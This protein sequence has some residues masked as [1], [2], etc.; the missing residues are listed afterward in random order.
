MINFLVARDE[1]YNILGSPKIV[2]GEG[3]ESYAS[4]SVPHEVSGNPSIL[5]LETIKTLTARLAT[6]PT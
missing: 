1:K 2:H 3:F 6:T 4:K 5:I